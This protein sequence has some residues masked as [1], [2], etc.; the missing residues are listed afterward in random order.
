[1]NTPTHV[2][3]KLFGFS[4]GTLLLALSHQAIAQDASFQGL[5]DLPGGSFFSYALGV[6]DGG[7]VVTGVGNSPSGEEAFRWTKEGGMVGL[8]NTL[9]GGFM[10]QAKRVSR[11][12][13]VTG[14]Y[15]NGASGI[16][17]VRW[18]PNVGTFL[19]GIPG[20]GQSDVRGVSA[21]GSALAGYIYSPNG[22]EAFRWTS[23][24]GMQTLGDLPGG[25][26]KSDAT[27]VSDGGLVVV[28]SSSDSAAGEVPFRWENGVMEP[29]AGFPSG[30]RGAALAVTPDG[31]VIVGFDSLPGVGSV[32]FRWTKS[33]GYVPLVGGTLSQAHGISGDG[34]VVVGSNTN[35]AFIWDATHGMR[36]LQSLLA[37]EYGLSTELNGWSLITA[38]AISSDGTA[39][40]GYGQNRSGQIEAWMATLPHVANMPPTAVAGFDQNLRV[41]TTVN[42]DGRASFDDNTA[43]ATLLYSWSFASRPAGSTAT[44]S[45]ATTATPS[46]VADVAGSYDVQLVVRDQEGL[47]NAP[48]HVIISSANLPPTAVATVDFSIVIIGTTAHLSGSASTDPEMNPLTYSWTITAKPS[49]STA[50]LVNATTATPSLTPDLEG[51][52]KVTL[53]VSDFIGPGT[54]ATI[55]LT[56]TTAVGFAE[57]QIATASRLISGLVKSQ[58]ANPGNQNGILEF[59]TQALQRLQDGKTA[60]AIV[61]LQ[62]SIE[63]SDGCVLRG[64]PD[65]LGHV[66]PAP[67]WITDC[68]A[69]TQVYV[70]LKNALDALTP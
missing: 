22:V 17:A 65:P 15:G 44:L 47:S 62:R 70:L 8:G 55:Q 19:I 57:F 59:L 7:N 36:D 6:S 64:S 43:S 42:L 12:G 61:W 58:F 67:D 51:V 5:N 23:A 56:A 68:A 39:I 29:L 24:G 46:F 48:D 1:M 16:R 2:I 50:T 35:G 18:E 66:P 49:G 33:G 45:N 21:D 34:S 20:G 13:L 10:V 26:F 31:S 54:P 63:R 60:E 41:G 14:G 37:T 69:Q 4:L 28:G 53:V 38:E 11:D 32:A 30:H 3:N 52:Y 25:S 9:V 27:A 40:A